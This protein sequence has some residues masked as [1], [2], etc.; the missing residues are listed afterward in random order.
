MRILKG[1]LCAAALVVSLEALAKPTTMDS[2]AAVVNDSII[3]QSQLAQH[4]RLITQQIQLSNANAPDPA[5]LEKQVL[6]HLILNEIQLQ[7]AKRTGIQVNEN[8]IDNAIE[9]IAKQSQMTV[10]QLREALSQEGLSYDHY[11]DNIRDQIVIHQL[12]QRDLMR[13]I[14][15]SDQEI[16]QFL[17]SP[18]GLGGMSHEFRLSHILIPLSE[19]PTPDE[20]D[21]AADRANKVIARLRNG[22]DFAQVALAEA[23]GQQALNGGDLGWRK[24]PELPT[25]FEKVVPTLGIG[26]IPSAIR[27]N[28]G[29]HVIKLVDKR[30]AS[31]MQSAVEKTLVRHIL[32]KTNTITSDHD[33]EKRLNEI[34]EKINQGEDFAKLAKAH[35]ADLGSASNG[36]SLGWVTADVLVPEFSSKMQTLALN[37]ISQPFKSPF[38]WHIMQV[39]ERKVQND[40]EAALRQKAREMLQQ[41][42]YEEKLQTWARQLRD[43]AYVI[44]YY[45]KR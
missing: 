25:L 41:R 44:T 5:M 3:T 21:Q 38:G 42:K 22:E 13:D 35:S 15:V 10:T 12:Q 11:R 4:V 27:S 31:Q 34:L 39:L 2:I 29:F 9:N 36:G 16:K 26:D 45:D 7:L 40:D 17:Q 32:I 14:H 8:D 28:S 19:S 33:A 6:E 37:E 30:S 1:I 23:Q 20:I 18:T 24:L 43:E